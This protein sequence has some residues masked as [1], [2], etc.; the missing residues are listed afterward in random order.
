MKETTQQRR[1]KMSEIR[2]VV[3]EDSR[4]YPTATKIRSGQVS[5][6]GRS[7]G[8]RLELPNNVEL[9]FGD[10][11]AYQVGQALAS[12]LTAGR[13]NN[14]VAYLDSA[15]DGVVQVGEIDPESNQGNLACWLSAGH[16]DNFPGA[17][18]HLSVNEARALADTLNRMADAAD[19]GYPEGKVTMTLSGSLAKP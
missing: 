8:V 12:C 10:N 18:A 3:T 1:M 2:I 13:L 19:E 11:T 5:E 9:I 17:P 16:C 7:K 6:L 15:Y 14:Q 4:D